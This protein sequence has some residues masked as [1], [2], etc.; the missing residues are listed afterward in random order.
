MVVITSKPGTDGAQS[1]IEKESLPTYEP[2][3]TEDDVVPY[4]EDASTSITSSEIIP[5]D[6]Y[7]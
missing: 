7:G 6:R 4:T 1:P 2:Y 3:Y 5:E